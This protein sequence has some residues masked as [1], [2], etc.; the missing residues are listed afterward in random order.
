MLSLPPD[1]PDL[2]FAE[3]GA[4][5]RGRRF[6]KGCG[7]AAFA[8]AL[9]GAAVVAARRAGSRHAWLLVAFAAALWL[10][11]APALGSVRYRVP[12]DPLLLVFA[13]AALATA[14]GRRWPALAPEPG[15]RRP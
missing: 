5:D 2:S 13:A 11:V 10:A 6:L 3:L 14:I 4:G 7:Y 12:I 15:A 9:A 1:E 8:L